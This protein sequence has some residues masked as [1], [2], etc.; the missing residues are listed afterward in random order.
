MAKNPM[1]LILAG[2]VKQAEQEVQ[3]I[4]ATLSAKESKSIS[5]Y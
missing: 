1:G 4:L 3:S 2:D 5:V